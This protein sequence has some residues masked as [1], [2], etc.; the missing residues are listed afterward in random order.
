MTQNAG[1]FVSIR[2]RSPGII[3]LRAPFATI[4]WNYIN[5]GMPLYREGTLK[6][7][8]VHSPVAFLLYKNG[9]IQE[10]E[11]MGPESLPNVKMPNRDGFAFPPDWKRGMPRLQNY[12]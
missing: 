10:D 9:V 12:P 6:P 3:A 11:V 4:I 2:L 8:V 1:D 7:K 5:R